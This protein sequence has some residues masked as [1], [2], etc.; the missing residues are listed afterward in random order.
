M[1]IF[2]DYEIISHNIFFNKNS[3]ESNQTYLTLFGISFL[4]RV[5]ICVYI[6]LTL[7]E[8]TYPHR[9]E[10]KGLFVAYLFTV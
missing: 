2:D 5:D 9:K 3:L 1:H 10:G 6:S 7:F 8:S 4:L